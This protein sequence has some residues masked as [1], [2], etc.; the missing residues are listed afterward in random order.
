LLARAELAGIDVRNPNVRFML[1]EQALPRGISFLGT[2]LCRQVSSAVRRVD[3]LR[4]TCREFGDCQFA[5]IPETVAFLAEYAP[6]CGYL[7]VVCANSGIERLGG[8]HVLSMF[9]KRNHDTQKIDVSVSGGN[10]QG[11]LSRDDVVLFKR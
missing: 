10:G 1:R 9:F 2:F 4:D 5:I 11:V 7:R 8:D 6:Y 3:F